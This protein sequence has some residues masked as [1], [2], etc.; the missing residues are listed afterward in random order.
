MDSRKWGDKSFSKGRGPKDRGN[1]EGGKGKEGD[2]KDLRG[3]TQ[4]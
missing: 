3:V 1:R 4:M 2:Y